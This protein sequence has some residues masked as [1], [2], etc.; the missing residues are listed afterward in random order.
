MTH[1]PVQRRGTVGAMAAGQSGDGEDEDGPGGAWRKA[2]YGAKERGRDT[3]TTTRSAGARAAA[4]EAEGTDEGG[5]QS[6]DAIST[7]VSE[8]TELPPAPRIGLCSYRAG[9][10]CASASTAQRA[11]SHAPGCADAR[12]PCPFANALVYLA[13]CVAHTPYVAHDLL[14]LHGAERVASLAHWAPRET[15]PDAGPLGAVEKGSRADGWE[16]GEAVRRRRIVLVEGRRRK[17]ARQTV[18]D[19]RKWV[20]NGDEGGVEVWDWRCLEEVAEWEGG[21]GRWEGE[22]EVILERWRFRR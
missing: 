13:P 6:Q 7:Q 9:H 19:G 15:R 20:G 3:E 4:H 10:V 17:Q 18:R 11:R 21:Q 22:L 2:G 1:E 14:P 16:D 12:P 8:D 5:E